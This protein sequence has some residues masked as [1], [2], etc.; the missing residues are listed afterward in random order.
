MSRYTLDVGRESGLEAAEFSTVVESDVEVVVDRTMLWGL[1]GTG[2]YGSHA[3][4][5]LVLPRT[6]W[7]L[8]EGATTGDF[9]LYYMLQNPSPSAAVVRVRYLRPNGLPPIER[10][11]TVPALRRLTIG[12]DLV[13]GLEAAEVSAA[14]RSLN[15]VPIIVER[16]MYLSRG[17]RPFESGHDSAAIDALSTRWFFA[18]GATGAMFDTY[19]L[20]ANPNDSPADVTIA[21]LLS[22]GATVSRAYQLRPNSRTTLYLAE[23]APE[24]AAAEVSSVVTVTNG[25][26]IAAERAMWW[27]S[28]RIA[29]PGSAFP[30]I[31]GE[32][33]NSPGATVTGT[34]WAVADGETGEL[35]DTLTYVMVANTSPYTADVSVT[36]LGEHGQ[37]PIVRRYTVAANSRFTVDMWTRFPE[38]RQEGRRTFATVVE[39]HPVGGQAP[40]QIVVERAMYSDAVGIRFAAGS[41]LLATRLR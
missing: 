13:P 12:V 22:T 37:E 19:L 10:D 5:S 2:S 6:E 15:G 35:G 3:E 29:A 39:S 33:H 4:S 24:L 18:E 27:P 17:L 25:V 30:I 9:Q 16:A 36:V 41:N 20:L 34:K 26:P 38:T 7:Y 21:Y 28:Y 40:A 32:A 23:Q 14:F 11:Y 8:A 1:A 31:W